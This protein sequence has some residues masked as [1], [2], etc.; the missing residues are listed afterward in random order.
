[1]DTSN[2]DK[3]EED[4]KEPFYWKD[5]TLMKKGKVKRIVSIII[6]NEFYRLYMQKGFNE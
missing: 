2:F 5:E 3:F 4:K 1:L 6:G